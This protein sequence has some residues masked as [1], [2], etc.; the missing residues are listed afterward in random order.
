MKTNA[1]HVSV[2]TIVP[3]GIWFLLPMGIEYSIQLHPLQSLLASEAKRKKKN[4]YRMYIT[5][6]LRQEGKQ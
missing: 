3:S 1:V 5:G 2:L 4:S 6:K